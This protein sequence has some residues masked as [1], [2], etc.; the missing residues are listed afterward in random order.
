MSSLTG[1]RA[2]STLEDQPGTA[3]DRNG[4]AASGSH[5]VKGRNKA[6]RVGGFYLSSVR[7]LAW[8]LDYSVD[9]ARMAPMW[10][11][12]KQEGST[13]KAWLNEVFWKLAV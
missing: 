6:E 7:A 2:A 12:I 13:M 8:N 10:P 9:E 11:V 5:V 1:A 4:P 3:A